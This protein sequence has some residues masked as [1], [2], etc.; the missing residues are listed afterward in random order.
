MKIEDFGFTPEMGKEYVVNFSSEG[1]LLNTSIYNG[2][3][4]PTVSFPDNKKIDFTITD[5][6]TGTNLM[7]TE[8]ISYNGKLYKSVFNLP[9]K[10]PINNENANVYIQ[11]LHYDLTTGSVLVKVQGFQG[12]KYNLL[13]SD[14]TVQH[15]TMSM[16][17]T[18]EDDT[19]YSIATELVQNNEFEVVLQDEYG[20]SIDSQVFTAPISTDWRYTNTVEDGTLELD[21]PVDENAQ[22]GLDGQTTD[23]FQDPL[24]IGQ[25]GGEG[26]TTEQGLEAEA[27][28]YKDPVFLG[29]GIGAL[30]MLLLLIILIKRRNARRSW[31]VNDGGKKGKGKGKGKHRDDEDEEDYDN[32]DGD[33]DEYDE[34]DEDGEDFPSVD[35]DEDEIPRATKR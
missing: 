2:S 17:I 12:D 19:Y 26:F 34:V 28:F 25:E 15:K 9:L 6:E 14:T 4:L 18:L 5:K 24:G 7:S 11:D 20:K 1:E 29:V 32:I 35:E 13:V 21:Q 10:N 33:G 16:P 8:F 23:D 27:P 3:P 30:V 31:G 22:D